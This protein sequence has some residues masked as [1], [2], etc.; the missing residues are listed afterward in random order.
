MATPDPY[1]IWFE[2][3]RAADTREVGGKFANLARLHSMGARVPRGF[4]VSTAAYRKF[5]GQLEDPIN[6]ILGVM[7][8]KDI[9]SVEKASGE[10]T[11]LVRSALVPEEIERSIRWAYSALVESESSGKEDLPVAV[12]S[13]A[14]AEDMQ[15]ASVAGQH[16]TFLWIRGGDRVVDHVREC[17]AS[18]FAA[19]SLSYRQA[20]QIAQSSVEM[21]VVVQKMV[22]SK[23]SGVMFTLN[24]SNGD[25][26]KIS[27]DSAWGLGEAVVS[28]VVS[29][30]LYVVDKVTLEI[31][32]RKISR[33]HL[34]YVVSGDEV[35]ESEVP[36]ERQ[37]MPSLSDQEV[38][39]LA[40]AA[41]SIEK[42]FGRPQDIEWA[43]DGSP[44]IAQGLY[45]LQA[46]PETVWSSRSAPK[47]ESKDSVDRVIDILKRGQKLRG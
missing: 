44:D 14:T 24:P 13:S 39:A 37:E 18:A 2:D 6:S 20:R 46:R 47:T 11:K 3:S 21:G 34:E 10:I 17:W 23:K 32:T 29:P 22:N 7:N 9:N 5:M 27:L 31:L 25:P 15:N 12:R 1:I 42:A 45:I 4:A 40:K 16:E 38:I 26:S 35:K 30:D 36:K 19:R 43:L 33:K 28:G 8:P 41:K